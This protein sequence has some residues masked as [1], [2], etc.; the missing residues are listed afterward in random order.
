MNLDLVAAVIELSSGVS[1]ST[2]ES[3]SS[4]ASSS[5]SRVRVAS[6][7]RMFYIFLKAS[8]MGFISRE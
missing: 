4:I 3:A 5:A 8:S 6:V 2:L 7:L 1:R